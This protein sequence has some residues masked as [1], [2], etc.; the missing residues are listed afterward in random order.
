MLAFQHRSRPLAYAD[1]ITRGITMPAK[2]LLPFSQQL[3]IRNQACTYI[4]YIYSFYHFFRTG[5]RAEILTPGYDCAYN[6][7][8]CLIRDGFQQRMGSQYRYSQP[9]HPIRLYRKTSF[10]RHG[11]HYRLDMCPRLHQLVRCQVTDIARS[12][13][14]YIFTQQGQFTVHHLLDYS[15]RINSRQIIILKG[16]HE[17]HRSCRHHQIIRIYKK[18]FFC[19][20]ILYRNPFPFQNIPHRAIQVNTVQILPSQSL[21][22]IKSPHP[23]ETLLLFK[24]KELVGLHCKLPTRT[25]IVVNHDIV[26]TVF[27]EFFPHCQSCRSRADNNNRSPQDTFLIHNGRFH[28]FRHEVFRNLPYFLHAVHFGNANATNLAVHQH[29]TSPALANS[30]FQRT[31]PS[32]QT[33]AMHRITSTMQSGCN[34][35]TFF[36]FYFLTV[37]FENNFFPFRDF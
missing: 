32:A 5:Y 23:S 4:N 16:R 8:L 12:H 20:D 11:F 13:S 17:G 1:G 26:H 36:P 19:A 3:A 30:T 14:Q 37:I 27:V 22:N 10:I 21:G 15:R 35:I 24:E 31:L 34:G 2:D 7:V 25:V 29:F 33:M 6:P 18:Y 28:L 9:P